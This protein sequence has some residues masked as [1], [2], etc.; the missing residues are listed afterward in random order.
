MSNLK[1]E[2]FY[3]RNLPHFVPPGATFFITFRL[4]GSIPQHILAGL[5]A[6]LEQRQA[7]LERASD[8]PEKVESLYLEQRRFFG[9]WDAV[10]GAGHGPDW[11]RQPPVAELVAGS[12]RYFDGQ[13][14]ELLAYCIMSNHVHLVLT[15]LLKTEQEY[16][17]LAQIMHSIKGYSATQANALLGRSGAF[18]Q[19]ENYD[20]Y[21]RS[22]AELE[23]IIWYVLNNPVKAGLV[24]DWTAWPWT[25]CKE[26]NPEACGTASRNPLDC[27]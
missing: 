15:P 6:E 23:R 5:K 25:Y 21:A 11:L 26:Y 7:E 20:H 1:P 19:H 8:A 24:D 14:Y 3:R 9:K 18:W 16:Y 27:A 17:P 4:A 10:L 22:G 13:R 2:A 12:M